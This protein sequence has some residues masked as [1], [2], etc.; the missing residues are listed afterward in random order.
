MTLMRT[1]SQVLRGLAKRL[2]GPFYRKLQRL[3][4]RLTPAGP[5]V[6]QPNPGPLISQLAPRLGAIPGWFNLD[7]L[8]HFTLVLETQSAAGL[9]GDLLEI[10]CFHGRSAAVLALHLQPGEQLYLVDAFDLPLPEIYGDTPSPAGVWRN[11]L[12]VVPDLERSRVHIE[13]AY[14]GKLRLPDG[15]RLRLAHVDGAHDAATARSDL[16]LCLRYLI[17]G[18]VLVVDDYAHPQHPGVS[19]AVHALLAGRPDLRVLADVNRLG[20]LGRKL[21]LTTAAPPANARP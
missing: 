17:P 4:R 5:P 18:G 15:L 7:D 3:Y 1:L 13:R 21:Y 8:T 11:L 9:T 20:A 19:Q 10:G 12:S 14:S 2:P 6:L 16:D